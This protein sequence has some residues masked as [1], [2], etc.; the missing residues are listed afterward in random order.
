MPRWLV[1]ASMTSVWRSD[2]CRM[3]SFTRPNPK[4]DTWRMKSKRL[5]SAMGLSPVSQS[6]LWHNSNGSNTCDK[7]VGNSYQ[8]ILT[9]K[10]S[11]LMFQR[12][13]PNSH[14]I[15]IVLWSIDTNFWK[16]ASR[17]TI[18]TNHVLIIPSLSKKCELEELVLAGSVHYET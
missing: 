1:I 12:M 10:T 16:A 7:S 3:S 17:E 8:Y 5:P 11:S 9:T 13:H 2:S 4:H 15:A 14:A 6:D 18:L